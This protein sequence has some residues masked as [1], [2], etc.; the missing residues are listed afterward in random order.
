M[1]ALEQQSNVKKV[2]RM[3][4]SDERYGL[5][6]F[7][8]TELDRAIFDG[9]LDLIEREDEPDLEDW[10]RLKEI[11]L[12]SSSHPSDAMSKMISALRNPKPAGISGIRDALQ[13][14]KAAAAESLLV[15][16]Q[17]HFMTSI[18]KVVEGDLG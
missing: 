7:I 15:R 1:T 5:L 13:S 17:I 12:L 3:L 8:S 4:L 14:I 16:M 2:A 11:C 9:L 18:G 6:N 10:A